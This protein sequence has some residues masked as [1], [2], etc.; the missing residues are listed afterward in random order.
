MKKSK[1]V[2]VSV[3]ALALCFLCFTSMTFSWFNRPQTQKGDSLG[4]D[5][6]Y[7][8]SVGSG[9]SMVTYESLDGGVSY[10]EEAPVTEFSN[11][12]GIAPGERKWYRTDIINNGDSAQTVSLYLSK[13]SLSP[14]A[15]GSFYLGVNAPLKT[16]KNY[17]DQASFITANEKAGI[18]TMRVYFQPKSSDMSEPDGNWKNKNYYVCYGVDNAP[19]NYVALSPTP[20]SGTYYADIPANATQ[21]FFSVQDWKESYQKTQTFSDLKSDGQSAVSSLVFWLNGTYDQNGNNNAQ[22]EKVKVT[23]G[24]NIVNYYKSI[25][26]PAEESFDA[27]LLMGTDYIGN[28][29]TYTSDNSNIFTVDSASGTISA[30]A[31]G[32]AKLITEV[33]GVFNDTV[34]V[35]TAVTVGKAVT[36]TVTADVPI[37]TNLRVEGLNENGESTVESIYWF[38]KNDSESGTLV[39]NV[40]DIYLTL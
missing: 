19:S 39:Y 25:T 9:V 29:V 3:L 37:I 40:E 17:F 38:I 15:Q 20:T 22:A 4:W 6:D 16:Y 30:K 21:L 34:R 2:L 5:I 8:I 36:E 7:E 18:S 33:K 32:T 12:E 23:E 14:D 11:T 13:L 1:L 24:A 28:S 35:E 26:L 27:S 10:N 31:E